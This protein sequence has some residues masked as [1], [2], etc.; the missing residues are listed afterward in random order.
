MCEQFL[1]AFLFLLDLFHARVVP[2]HFFRQVSRSSVCLPLT[3]SFLLKHNTEPIASDELVYDSMA[4][5]LQLT[6]TQDVTRRS[7]GLS[8]FSFSAYFHSKPDWANVTVDAAVKRDLLWALRDNN[9]YQR[10]YLFDR[11]DFQAEMQE[12][13][14]SIRGNPLFASYDSNLDNLAVTNV[15]RFV[16]MLSGSQDFS[17]IYGSMFPT[18]SMVGDSWSREAEMI[19]TAVG[20][21]RFCE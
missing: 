9:R 7:L 3:P 10:K 8:Q 13:Y 14:S 17:R 5:A 2:E 20:I 12:Y 21:L 4:L 18:R 1:F 19:H 6:Q 15:W 11:I 16:G